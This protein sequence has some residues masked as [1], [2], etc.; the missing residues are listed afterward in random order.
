M[1][2]ILTLQ[3]L[4]NLESGERD[5]DAYLLKRISRL[6][7]HESDKHLIA[8]VSYDLYLYFS[9]TGYPDKAEEYLAI[10]E[11]TQDYNH[12]VHCHLH[13]KSDPGTPN[14]F[15]T[16]WCIGFTFFWNVDYENYR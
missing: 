13:H 12:T 6:L 4:N 9:K 7:S 11:K 16:D 15:V 1:L 3:L 2:L 10:A 8:L 14:L 5:N